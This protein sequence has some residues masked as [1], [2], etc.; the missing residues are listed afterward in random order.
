MSL[1]SSGKEAILAKMS[2]A[3]FTSSVT[4]MLDLMKLQADCTNPALMILEAFSK[5]NEILPIALY[6]I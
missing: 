6:F 3:N 5:N 4:F 2:N 1:I